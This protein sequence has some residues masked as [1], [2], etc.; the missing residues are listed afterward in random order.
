MKYWRVMLKFDDKDRSEECLKGNFIG[1]NYGINEDIS[2]H[3]S[4]GQS[5]FTQH[6][7]PV[8]MK[9]HG[10]TR[11]SAGLML[12][13]LWKIAQGAKAGDIVL[14]PEGNKGIYRVGKIADD[15]YRYVAGE[16]FLH[17]RP[18]DWFAEIPR[19]IMSKRLQDSAGNRGTIADISHHASEINRLIDN[20]HQAGEFPATPGK[21]PVEFASEKHLQDYLVHH[22]ERMPLLGSEYKIHEDDGEQAVE[23]KTDSGG[24][25]DILAESKDGGTLL[26]VEIK[27]GK[28]ESY[29]VG[30]TLGYIGDIEKQAGK[31]QKV[32]GAIIASAPGARLKQALSQTDKVDFY[33]Y[34]IQFDIEIEKD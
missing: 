33:R 13:A 8:Y 9:E 10:K 30:Q 1:A 14:S 31:N 15:G 11:I 18:V 21:T 12:G 3:L 28:A 24:S 26:V 34:N 4:G 5:A 22:W 6:Y 17:R 16:K 20:G 2:R 7:A 23:Y 27:K 29:A 25:I 32:R 19:D